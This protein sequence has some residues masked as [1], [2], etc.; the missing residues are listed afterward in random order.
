ML[1]KQFVD[2]GLGNSSYLIASE[3]TGLAAVLDVA[4][5]GD[6]IM[7]TSFG[8]GAG[9]DSFLIKAAGAIE[10]KRKKES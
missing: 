7:V 9:S 10:K 4:K 5:P 1:V 2:E 3:E 8:S 6:T